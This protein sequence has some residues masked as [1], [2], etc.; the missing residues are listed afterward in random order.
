MKKAPEV[1]LFGSGNYNTL[2][3]LHELAEAGITPHILSV[4]NPKDRKSGNIIG[5]SKYA[6][7]IIQVETETDGIR[8]IEDN[9][10]S[11]P[12]GT[13]IYPT[14][15]SV[16]Q[17]L[18]LAYD[19]L[20]GHFKFPNACKAGAVSF[21]MDK[22]R[23]TDIA[24]NS[25]IRVLDS[26]Y[27]NSP[28][29][30]FHNITY[31]CMVKPLNS[32]AGSKSDMRVCENEKEVRE[33]LTGGKETHEF[34]VQQYI[35]NEADLLFL[36]VAM[37][38]G[39]IWLPA[40]IIKPGVSPTGEYT[41]ATVS[42]NVS[43]YLPDIQTVKTFV[44]NLEYKGPFSIEF[45]LEKGI[46][47]FFEINLRNDGTSH[48]PLSAGVN[49]AAAYISGIIPAETKVVEYDMIDEITDLKRVFNREISLGRWC[50][51]FF[52]A[53]S[54]RYYRAGDTKLLRPLIPMFFTRL[55]GKFL[56]LLKR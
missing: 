20:S 48:Y 30:S 9:K 21:L 41:H 11:F 54:Y 22:H 49:I 8:W 55:S 43:K 3:V 1:I 5:Y 42:T 2:G 53:G 17:L 15:D 35:H 16:E 37:D 33:A 34:I 12:A 24:K 56:R 52:N 39:E 46:P 36:G 7:K 10:D 32:T 40:V 28:D 44:R 29:F 13:I 51:S 31:P 4:G 38:N 25:G 14:S 6:E 18:D 19:M 26:Q 45:G 23:Q 27:T 50:K 47:Y